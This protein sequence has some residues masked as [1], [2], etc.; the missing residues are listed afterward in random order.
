MSA[1]RMT[2]E[3]DW[4]DGINAFRLKVWKEMTKLEE[5]INTIKQQIKGETP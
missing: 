1:D 2:E 3:R 4:K 5:E